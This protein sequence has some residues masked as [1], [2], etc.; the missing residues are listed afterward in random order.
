MRDL[1]VRSREGP[2]AN[3][4][5]A[6]SRF[7]AGTVPFLRSDRMRSAASPVDVRLVSTQKSSAAAY[8]LRRCAIISLISSADER[9][10]SGGRGARASRRSIVAMS[11][12]RSTHT[13]PA[14][15][16]SML[17]GSITAPPPVPMT[18][19]RRG[20]PAITSRSRSR[21]RSSPS[22]RKMPGI[23]R[24]LCCSMRESVSRNDTPSRR[25]RTVPIPVFPVPR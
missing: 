8:W 2:A 21:N 1:R 7:G 10:V 17:T 13:L 5:N 19:S 23:V 4:R 9:D 24:P 20:S 11:A 25:A 6:A 3:H 15:R 14:R 22:S 18:Q 16:C 12:V